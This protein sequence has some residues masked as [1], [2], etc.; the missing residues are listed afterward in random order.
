M[1]GRI[2]EHQK[3]SYLI[4]YVKYITEEEKYIKIAEYEAQGWR[5]QND[6]DR[7]LCFSMEKER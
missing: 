5:C 7:G 6:I 1:S 4:A 3:T 2:R